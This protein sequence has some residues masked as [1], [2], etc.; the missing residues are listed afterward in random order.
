MFAKG[1]YRESY[2]VIGGAKTPPTTAAAPAAAAAETA[3]FKTDSITTDS[4][5]FILLTQSNIY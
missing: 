1:F 5:G 3:Q 2:F 4:E